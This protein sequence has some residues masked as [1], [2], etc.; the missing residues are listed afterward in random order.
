M[1]HDEANDPPRFPPAKKTIGESLMRWLFPNRACRAAVLLLA[2]LC[3][4]TGLAT[5]ADEPGEVKFES[6]ILPILTAHCFKCHGLEA[7]KAGLDLRSV[8]MMLRGGD[9]GPTIVRG[10]AEKSMLFER[11]ADRSMPPEKELP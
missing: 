11:I 10:S 1:D 9:N 3:G 5:M 2:L 4:P 8:G 6:D 7:R